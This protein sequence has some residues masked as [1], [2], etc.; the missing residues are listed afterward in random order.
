M[1]ARPE[2][3]NVTFSDMLCKKMQITLKFC[4]EK[5]LDSGK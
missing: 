3:A 5:I 2:F 1:V 4:H